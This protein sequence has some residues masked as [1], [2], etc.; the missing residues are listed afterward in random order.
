MLE[1]GKIAAIL[2]ALKSLIKVELYDLNKGL[3]M[4]ILDILSLTQS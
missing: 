3:I 4:G 2:I 1:I